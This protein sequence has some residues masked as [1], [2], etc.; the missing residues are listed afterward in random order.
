MRT[1]LFDERDDR[2]GLALLAFELEPGL[3]PARAVG[4]V[5]AFGDQ[6]FQSELAGIPEYL[7]TVGFDVLNEH[8]GFGRVFQQRLKQPLALDKR[9]FAQVVP[10]EIKQVEGVIAYAVALARSQLAPQL[11]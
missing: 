10:V 11:L 2:K 7:L 9:G 4:R 6:A 1:K 8:K 3:L 5:G